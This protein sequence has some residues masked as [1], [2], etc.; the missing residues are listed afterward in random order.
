[1]RPSGIAFSILSVV[2]A[3][4]CGLTEPN[5]SSKP[6]VSAD[7]E[8]SLGLV[9]GC[10]LR[11]SKDNP[12]GFSDVCLRVGKVDRQVRIYR[13]GIKSKRPVTP[14]ALV[15][16]LHG[17]GGSGEKASAAD[18]ALSVFT[19][20][21]EADQFLVVYPSGLADAENK[22][23]WNDCRA[24]DRSKTEADD[25]GFIQTIISQ[26]AQ[27]FSLPQS[28]IFIAGTSN[29]AMM[30][31]RF[32]MENSSSIGAVAAASG[33][34]AKNPLSGRCK[35][36]PQNPVPVLMAHGTEDNFVPYGGGCVTPMFAPKCERGE[37]QSADATIKF[38][39]G[40]NGLARVKPVV[41]E[42]NP[43]RTDGGS[44]IERKYSLNG[45]SVTTW[46]LNGAGHVTPSKSLDAGNTLLGKQNQDIEFA[47]AAW[48]FFK[49]QMK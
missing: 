47:E 44:A 45:R 37:V 32:A 2:F 25:V 18:S 3:G 43:S 49:A 39:L 13:P 26:T 23:G 21:A 35:T 34:I 19:Q 10:A 24:D 14:Q 41:R 29:G 9:S 40:V 20:Y 22:A 11:L 36:G 16:V 33:N 38:W 6:V 15:V 46:T 31:Y 1:M 27:N 17:G 12:A 7:S 48:E 28:R 5:V 30:S 42:I 8:Q 4:A